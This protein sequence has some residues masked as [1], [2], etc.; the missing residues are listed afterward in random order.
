MQTSFLQYVRGTVNENLN[1]TKQELFRE[2]DVIYRGQSAREN[3]LMQI[4]RHLHNHV[5]RITYTH[6]HVLFG[7]IMGN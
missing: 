4:R 7:E 6:V 2:A 5:S 1:I 3:P